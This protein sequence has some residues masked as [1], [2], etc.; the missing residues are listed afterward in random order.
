M[1]VIPILLGAIRVEADPVTRSAAINHQR[2]HTKKPVKLSKRGS[3]RKIQRKT[4]SRAI[5]VVKRMY[6]GLPPGF[7]W[8]PSRAMDDAGKA[9]ERKLDALGVQWKPARRQGRIADPIVITDGMLGGIEYTNRFGP[10]ASSTMECQLGLAL[11]T[12]GPELKGLGVREVK[13]GSIYDLSYI[14]TFRGRE[15]SRHAIAVAMDI[16]AFV[17]DTGREVNVETSYKDGDILLT[18]VESLFL[19]TGEF[20]N[21]ITPHN[22]PISHYNHFHVEAVVSFLAPDAPALSTTIARSARVALQ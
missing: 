16:G 6:D 5:A 10:K 21:I 17:D 4:F 15:L 8:P 13:F 12:I 1:L 11:A 2:K 18:A 7:S 20:H 19:A 3:T 22:D 9:C 14:R